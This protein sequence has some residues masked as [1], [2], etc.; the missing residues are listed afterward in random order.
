MTLCPGL[1]G[2]LTPVTL[3]PIFIK[4]AMVVCKLLLLLLSLWLW[5]WLWLWL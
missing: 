1:E 3:N 2:I 4:L 5:L